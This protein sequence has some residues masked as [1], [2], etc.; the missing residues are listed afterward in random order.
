MNSSA[1]FNINQSIELAPN[2]L[3]YERFKVGALIETGQL[4]EASKSYESI[5][6]RDPYDI[7]SRQNYL[8]LMLAQE[9]N[10]EALAILSEIEQI[11]GKTFETTV[12]KYELLKSSGKSDEALQEL[13]ELA[14]VQPFDLE[15][16]L[17]I[18]EHYQNENNH[19]AASETLRKVA[20]LDPSN[21]AA[22]LALGEY[23]VS[24][25][26]QRA[27]DHLLIGISD[28]SADVLKKCQI[29]TAAHKASLFSSSQTNE[30]FS[31]L[32]ETHTETA[33]VYQTAATVSSANPEMALEN[34]TKFLELSPGDVN[35]WISV[36]DLAKGLDL[37]K[38]QELGSEAL[39]LYPLQPQIY[40][41][42]GEIL[43]AQENYSEAI[44]TLKNGLDITIDLDKKAE[45]QILLMEGSF[46]SGD[47]EMARNWL[48]KSLN[49]LKT[50]SQ[51]E[52]AGD[53]SFKN[54]AASAAL[55]Y[56]K[57]ALATG[58]GSEVLEEKIANEA[59]IEK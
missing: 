3:W 27:F 26:D 58:E 23:Y 28:S 4:D 52:L 55:N 47:F 29:L 43:I 15:T 38:A 9:N 5:L 56:W 13:T 25:K 10:S 24:Q 53:V 39:E 22:Q 48:Q 16:Q 51:L 30:L 11:Q 59:Y 1:L 17:K 33:E 41:S 40:I 42:H 6:S 31:A 18:A 2:N 21:G 46:K 12:Q 36:L 54:G 37:S 19:S 8:S 20:E 35:S 45:I 34:L 7:D 14:K 49:N 57:Q 44:T 32:K 50:G